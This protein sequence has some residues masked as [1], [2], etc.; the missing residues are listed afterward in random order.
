MCTQTNNVVVGY[1]KDVT[2]GICVSL[3]G[4][5]AVFQIHT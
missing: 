4:D 1:A 3:F 2:E 5:D